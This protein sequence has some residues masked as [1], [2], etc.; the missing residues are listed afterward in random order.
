MQT[1]APTI[2]ELYDLHRDG[3]LGDHDP[4]WKVVERELR[5]LAARE[6]GRANGRLYGEPRRSRVEDV[7]TRLLCKFLER[8]FNY[9]GESMDGLLASAARNDTHD[10]FRRSRS[11]S[12]VYF[13]GAEHRW[14]DDR[15]PVDHV[16]PDVFGVVRQ[17]MS[18][19]RFPEHPHV[20]EAVLSFFL[21]NSRYPGS[22]FLHA[23][24]VPHATRSAVYNAAVVD[25]NTAMMAA[26]A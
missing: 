2:T 21:T 20:R 22:S 4:R 26:C 25:I 17:G 15:M 23:L 13:D 11:P 14:A 16:D 8:R 18:D 9:R 12:T 19:F 6:V 3:T 1:A 24:T 10:S 7:Y 5:R